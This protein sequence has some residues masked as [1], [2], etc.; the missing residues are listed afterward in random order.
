MFAQP[1]TVR[2]SEP[3]PHMVAVKG[4]AQAVSNEEGVP[5]EHEH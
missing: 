4:D 5:P 3:L 1:D 2:T